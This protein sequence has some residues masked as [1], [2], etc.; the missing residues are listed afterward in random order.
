[1]ARPG[2]LGM[3]NVDIYFIEGVLVLPV[4][5]GMID[6]RRVTVVGQ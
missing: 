4:A 3:A 6:M 2:A 1:M 5:G